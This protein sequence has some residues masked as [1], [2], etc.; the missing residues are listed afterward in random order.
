MGDMFGLGLDSP[1][2]FLKK[3]ELNLAYKR[4]KEPISKDYTNER[5]Q[6][7]ERHMKLSSLNKQ[8]SRSRSPSKLPQSL[9]KTPQRN[10]SK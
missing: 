1:M 6:S 7:P 10:P 2:D 8:S 9:T 4:V 3:G 5:L